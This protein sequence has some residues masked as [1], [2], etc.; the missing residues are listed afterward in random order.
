MEL[1][2]I[3]KYWDEKNWKM[4]YDRYVLLSEMTGEDNFHEYVEEL[5]LDVFETLD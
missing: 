3:Q 4:S 1:A 2:T 5:G